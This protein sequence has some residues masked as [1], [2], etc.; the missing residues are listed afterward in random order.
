MAGSREHEIYTIRRWMY[1][2]RDSETGDVTREFCDGL[3]GF[4]Y[5]ATNQPFARDNGLGLPSEM[6]DVCV[7][8]CM[9]FWKDDEKLQECRFCG[10]PRYQDTQGRTR[11]PYKRMWYLPITDRL[12]RLYQ[13]KRTAAAMRWH[14]EHSTANGEITHPS[15][16]KAWKHFQTM[17]SAHLVC[18][19]V[20]GPKHPKRALDI[21]LQP[22]IHELKQLWNEG[23]QT[24]DYSK[25]QN[26]NMRAVLMW[27]ISD[28]PA[29]GMLSGWTTHGRLSCPYC[30][31]RT[32]AF[33][34]KNG[35]K[36]CWFD[37]H[38]RFLPLHHPYR[39]NKKWFRKNKVVRVPPPSYVSGNY[40]LEQIDYYGAQETC[41]VGGNWHTPANMPDGY[42][43]THNW[44]KQ[45]IFWELPYWKDLLL[46]H[47]LD[48]MH[49]EKNVF[50]NIINTLLNVQ[51]KTKDNMK[52]RLD[53]VEICARVEL[54]L[55]RN[56][57]M[58][59]SNFRLTADAK[60]A[61]F[62]WI[63]SE[64]KFPDGYVSKFSRCV[65]QGQKFS[66]MKSHDCHVFMQQLLPFVFLELLPTHV[67]EAIAGIG[68]FFRDL[69]TR[70]L[71]WD[72]IQQL[73]DNIPVLICNLEK[74]FP[75]SFFDVMEHLPI[76]LPH[77]AAL[78]GPV[79]FRWMYPFERFM[80]SLKGKAKNL[81]R[82][83]G[84]IVAG[85]LTEET[86]HFTSY[87]FS[88]SVRTKKTRLRRYDDGGVA[89]TYN[90][91]DVPDVFAQ[92]GRLAGKLKEV[93]WEDHA[94]CRAAH[95]YILRNLDYIQS[96]E[97]I[98]DSQIR[99]AFPNLEEKD[100]ESYKDRDFAGWLKYYVQNGCGNEPLPLWLHEI[101]QE[102]RAKITTAPMY[103][104]RGYTFHTYRHGIRRATAN[105][106]IS[107]KAGD[108]EFYGILQQILE[109]EYP[110]L[111]NLK[112]ILF[113]CDWYDPTMGRG[114]R[115][116]NLGVVDVN[117]NKTYGRFD[118]YILASQ[119]E[120]VSFLSYP[121]L[122]QRR[123]MWLSVIKVNP[124]GRIIGGA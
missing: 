19:G 57:K 14:A 111:L 74:I 117:T 20:P 36:P 87:Y 118:P 27:T 45:S 1:N 105:Y 124:R 32:D 38:R 51:G 56:G 101:V 81:A 66:G 98:F 84:S 18:L 53:L 11:V 107:V 16:A 60:K 75:P 34:L 108:S 22:L 110:G 83:E 7:D 31:E 93:W 86:S 49:I 78:G 100:Y 3:R 103:F 82:V 26:F 25:K 4:M 35:R 30:M 48:V 58:P 29:Y 9:I 65:E 119:A 54:H 114:M 73:D 120:Q 68:A 28:F 63:T 80:K 67:H 70:T 13:S 106:G 5:Q 23:V 72:G 77:E 8:Y 113:K 88:P 6:I 76:H 69:C 41:K 47:N 40:L 12:K 43:C 64:V 2:H 121:R 37:C 24:F 122:R 61:L 79:Q 59:I 39:K 123:E 109:V 112:C 92:I 10:K 85:S 46:R 96:F 89:Q 116:N 95:N 33:Q 21:F 99:E 17:D 115:A 42:T 62:E 15:D 102:P 104:T 91:P 90:V 44:H 55:M 97:R 52:S 71:S 50:D 94:Y